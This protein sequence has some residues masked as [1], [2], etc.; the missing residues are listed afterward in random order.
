[1]VGSDANDAVRTSPHP[2][3]FLCPREMG[4]ASICIALPGSRFP[5]C[6]AQ[7]MRLRTAVGCYATF[8]SE[9]KASIL[10]ILK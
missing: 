6:S 3:S 9:W 8:A 4:V 7:V 2:T 10:S 5:S 1:M